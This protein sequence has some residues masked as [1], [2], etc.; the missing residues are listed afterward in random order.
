MLMDVTAS[1]MAVHCINHEDREVFS[2]T[3]DGTELR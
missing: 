3:I 2:V 1:R